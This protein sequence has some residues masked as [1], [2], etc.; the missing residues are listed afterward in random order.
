MAQV[1]KDL[2]VV[3]FSAVT[4]GAGSTAVLADFGADVIKIESWDHPDSFRGGLNFNTGNTGNS[5]EPVTTQERAPLRGPFTTVNRNKRAICID[6]KTP[7]GV[8]IVRRLVAI[9]DVVVENF[10]RGVIERW[11]LGFDEL[12]K[13]KKDIVL[14][15][16]SSQGGTGPNAQY[17]SFGS[18]LDALGGTAS[19]TGYDIDT[20]R[21]SSNR[22]NYPDQLVS[23]YAP[24]LIV[25]AV[26]RARA[27]GEGCWV[28]LSQ[29]ELTTSVVGELLLARSVTGVDPIPMG[30]EGLTGFEWVSPASG[31]DEWIAISVNTYA[32]LSAL[33]DVLG[34]PNPIAESAF[35]SAESHSKNLQELQQLLAPW[36]SR[37]EKGASAG[38]LQGVG[39][40]AVPVRKSYELLED[41]ELRSIGF[42]HELELPTRTERERGFLVRF[43]DPQ[44]AALLQR[45]APYIGE[46]TTEVLTQLLNYSEAEVDAFKAEGVVAGL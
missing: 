18:V 45:R 40:P 46:Q 9:S 43:E 23:M 6:M 21:W 28:D 13:V 20:P 22:V 35:D 10:R 1:L 14:V 5:G 27:R 32:Q 24:G 25:A 4:A 11:G 31:D 41:P 29:R 7:H 19:V 15:T 30:N 34:E 39:I 42:Y 33:C 8:D 26:M 36:T 12:V 37:Q 44:D 38:I 2:R 17:G 16:I 3:D